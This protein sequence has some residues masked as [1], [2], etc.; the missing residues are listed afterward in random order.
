MEHFDVIVVGGGHAGLEAAAAASR[1]GCRVGLVTMRREDLGTMSCNPAIGGVGKGHLVREIDALDGLMGRLGDASAIQYRLLNRRKGAAVRGPR[2]QADRSLYRAA[3]HA[4]LGAFPTLTIV[5][6]EAADLLRDGKRISAV[7]LAD[8]T[9]LGARSVVLATGTFLGGTI[10]I[11]DQKRAAGR[12]GDAAAGRI[13]GALR[14]LGLNTKR[15]KT[16][17]PPRLDGRSI[18]WG[19]L[20]LQ[21]SDACPSYLSFRTGSRASAQIAC[22]VT[23]TNPRTHDIIRTN[24]HRSAMYG[25]AISGAGP[26]YCPS[27]EDKIVRFSD[28]DSHQIFL[29]PEG[30]QTPTV[31]PNGLS[32]SLPADVQTDYLRSIPG[33]EAVRI[34]QP[35]YAVEYDFIDPRAL[36]RR[37]AVKELTNLFFAGQING[38]TGYEEAA[39]QGLVA[40]LNAATTALDESEPV[41]FSRTSSYIGVMIDD[42]VTNG[43][44]EP[45]R[46]FTS[47]AEF[48]LS[49]RADNADQRLTPQ[50]RALGLV[51]AQRWEMFSEKME[52]LEA[53]RTLLRAQRYSPD[54]IAACG[55]DIA[56]DGTRRSAMTILGRADLGRDCLRRLDARL[57]DT[58]V[59]EQLEIE[60][61]YEPYLRRQSLDAE[62]L[63]REERV[64]LPGTLNYREVPGLSAELR[65]KL[66]A[67]RPGTVAEARRI[68]G[69]TP[70]ALALLVA[71]AKRDRN[72]R[73]FT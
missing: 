23:H 49:L 26:R 62:M 32:T 15:L 11:G 61:H 35:G 6:G 39:A 30:L 9:R 47:R 12:M 25:G 68:E 36:D 21:E 19:S 28:K 69:I 46:M 24:L 48:R 70:A 67:T 31:Y 65:Q 55:F 72:G 51:S 52:A 42:L 34:T 50:G 3:T 60:A 29:E 16:G 58:D 66:S 27:I 38:T 33:L 43:A 73:R 20:G 40:G 57:P 5:I 71:L 7:V 13:A 22:G 18:G 53:G 17:T 2:V 10:H 37:L 45:Y 8:G 14:E 1:L 54:T 41:T 56:R 59:L 4:A 64:P 63:A 44:S